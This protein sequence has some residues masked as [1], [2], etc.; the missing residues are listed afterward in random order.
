MDD[1]RQEGADL[2]GD[3]D[4]VQNAAALML[5]PPAAAVDGRNDLGESMQQ[6][7]PVMLVLGI[8]VGLGWASR[9]YDGL[10]PNAL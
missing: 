4:E 6:R 5:K 3:P 2:Q 7:L 8:V 1:V 9:A 10:I